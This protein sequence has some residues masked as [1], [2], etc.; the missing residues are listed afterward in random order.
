MFAVAN[1]AGPGSAS[2]APSRGPAARIWLAVTRGRQVDDAA[3]RSRR[4]P[5][6]ATAASTTI[7]ASVATWVASWL[8][9]ICGALGAEPA[10]H[11]RVDED[12]DRRGRAQEPSTVVGHRGDRVV[13][14]GVG[15]EHLVA[16]PP[17][18]PAPRRP[19]CPRQRGST[20]ATSRDGPVGQRG[21]PVRVGRVPATISQ[22][23]AALRRTVSSVDQ[24][25]RR[26][27]AVVAGADAERGPVAGLQRRSSRPRVLGRRLRRRRRAAS[28]AGPRRPRRGRRSAA[29]PRRTARPRLLVDVAQR[30]VGRCAAPGRCR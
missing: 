28:R 27:V 10:E 11:R 23:S 25:E 16:G 1:S 15:A 14:A 21:V 18:S 26:R 6:A 9:T 7:A 20:R 2:A 4:T 19:G 13:G 24:P 29:R 17:R 8:I 22:R 3:P 12:V 5:R 30:Q